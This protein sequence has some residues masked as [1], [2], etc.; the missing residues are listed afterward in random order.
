VFKQTKETTKDSIETMLRG[1][2][3]RIIEA[4]PA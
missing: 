3:V 4:R 1:H 2:I